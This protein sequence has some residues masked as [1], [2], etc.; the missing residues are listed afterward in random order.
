ME[1]TK[2]KTSKATQIILENDSGKILVDAHFGKRVQNLSGGTPSAYFR[3]STD[4]QT[5]LVRGEVEVRGEILDWL[6]VVLLSIQRERILKASF[7]SSNQPALILRYNE[8]MERFD[9]QDLAKDREI[10]SRYRVLNV[11][12]IPE[13]L[14]LKMFARLNSHRPQTKIRRMANPDGLIV[15]LKLARRRKR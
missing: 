6:S 11:G 2:L 10:K 12:T 15:T 5:W 7:R 8:D 1:D 14:T 13:N 9:I 3:Q 4:A